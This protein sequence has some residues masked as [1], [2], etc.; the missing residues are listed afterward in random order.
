MI[1][2]RLYIHIQA[3]DANDAKLGTSAPNQGVRHSS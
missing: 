3:N 2:K 1:T